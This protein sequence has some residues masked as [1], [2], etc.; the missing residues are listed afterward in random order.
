[1]AKKAKDASQAAVLDRREEM[2]KLSRVLNKEYGR[3]GEPVIQLASELQP[4]LRIAT[5]ILS[6]DWLHGG[7]HP[8]GLFSMF[9]GPE[10]AGKTT[11]ALVELAC[12]QAADPNFLGLLLDGSGRFDAMLERARSIGV[13]MDR[14]FPV[15][16]DTIEES[17]EILKQI[18]R[19]GLIDMV[20]V[21]DLA[22]Y[23]SVKAQYKGGFNEQRER[24]MTDQT[25]GAQALANSQFISRVKDVLYK[26]KVACVFTQ[27]VRA[28]LDQYGGDFTLPGGHMIKHI[29]VLNTLLLQGAS[30]QAPTHNSTDAG[31]ICGYALKARVTKMSI[32]GAQFTGTQIVTQFTHGRGIERGRDAFI[33]LAERKLALANGAQRVIDGAF[34]EQAGLPTGKLAFQGRRAC[35]S[36]LEDHYPHLYNYFVPNRQLQIRPEDQESVRRVTTED[37]QE[38]QE[39]AQDLINDPNYDPNEEDN[40]HAV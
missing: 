22:V 33:F 34:A 32:D 37:V 4:P 18:C 30:G 16:T 29:L 9:W 31:D 26:K 40:S 3:P 21:D 7:G 17:V 14:F 20:I 6:L 25:V 36:F 38:A 5:G 13:D 27:Q 12:A 28:N 24:A 11:T 39:E 35:E 8:R 15:R 23:T 19:R 10:G 2:I 1:M